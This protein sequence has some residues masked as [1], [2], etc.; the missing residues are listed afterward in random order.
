MEAGALPD[1]SDVRTANLLAR[2]DAHLALITEISTLMYM[3]RL[4]PVPDETDPRTWFGSA[5]AGFVPP[6]LPIPS[7]REQCVQWSKRNV[8]FLSYFKEALSIFR[9][10]IASR[11]A[12]SLCYENGG[13]YAWGPPGPRFNVLFDASINAENWRLAGLGN[14]VA[15]LMTMRGAERQ[16]GPITAHA[17]ALTAAAKAAHDPWDDRLYS[18]NSQ[19]ANW[20]YHVDIPGFYN[21][22]GELADAATVA[23]ALPPGVALTEPLP[24]GPLTRGQLLTYMKNEEEAR[25]V[26][27][28]RT[29]E[30]LDSVTDFE[31]AAHKREVEAA[32]AVHMLRRMGRQVHEAVAVPRADAAA[33][34]RRVELAT[35]GVSAQKRLDAHVDDYLTRLSF[36]EAHF[37]N[38]M[39]IAQ[40]SPTPAALAAVEA[41]EREIE[42]LVASAESVP[43]RTVARPD[44][45][46]G[47]KRRRRRASKRSSRKS[48]ASSRRRAK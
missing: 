7:T 35:A 2:I 40:R 8:E 10:C 18:D 39:A 47:A 22:M 6:E 17:R 13:L 36:L 29:K 24:S 4:Y 30:I 42:E 32:A 46:G 19:Y 41:A 34:A 31:R 14:I 16:Q 3:I 37:K 23:G 48:R 9:N 26:M 20:A 28:A 43:L 45:P 1:Y 5:P 21:P 33:A 38:V 12:D 11:G 44:M 27:G 25:R 15:D